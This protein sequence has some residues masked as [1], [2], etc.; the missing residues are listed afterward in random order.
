MATSSGWAL[1]MV[2]AAPL[3]GGTVDDGTNLFRYAWYDIQASSRGGGGGDAV[4]AHQGA[5]LKLVVLYS[6]Q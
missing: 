4:E 6:L 3:S 2:G 5:A 1:N